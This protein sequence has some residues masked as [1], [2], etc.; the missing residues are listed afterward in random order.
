MRELGAAARALCLIL[1]AAAAVGV[2]SVTA[3]W[4]GVNVG[5]AIS[6]AAW[7]AAVCV[8]FTVLAGGC[9]R[10]D[11]TRKPLPLCDREPPR[12]RSWQILG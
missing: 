2:A 7:A 11:Y 5:A 8:R 3:L 12:G 4:A 10:W 6:A 9:V 1:A